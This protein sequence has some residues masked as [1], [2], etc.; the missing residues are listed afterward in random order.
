MLPMELQNANPRG[1]WR[2][3]NGQ[4]TRDGVVG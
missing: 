1:V 4:R 2:M 3:L